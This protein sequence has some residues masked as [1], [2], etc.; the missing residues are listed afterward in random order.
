MQRC[1]CQKKLPSFLSSEQ[2][3]AGIFA[4]VCLGANDITRNRSRVIFSRS[5]RRHFSPVNAWSAYANLNEMA[6]NKI[7]PPIPDKLQNLILAFRE[8]QAL[9]AAYE[10]GIFDL[11][12]DSKTLLSAEDIAAKINAD[13]DATARLMDTL[14]ALELL[15]KTQEYATSWLYS[16]TKIA[17]QFLTKSSPDSVG[18]YITHST[19]LVYPLFGNLQSAV[20]EGSTQWMNTF[21]MSSED[22]WKSSY[23]NEEARLRFLG[24]MHST[25]RHTCHAVATA[26]DLSNFHSCC[27]LGGR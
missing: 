17:S 16:N 27:D 12:H 5:M 2:H 11:L 10:L 22:M 4:S 9:F 21:G 18:G 3:F 1:H 25:S 6:H 13:S 14:V 7:P 26:F 15:E 24:A 23:H 20:R 19:K 8:S